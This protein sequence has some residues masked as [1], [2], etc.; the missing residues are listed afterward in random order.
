MQAEYEINHKDED[1]LNRND[2][3]STLANSIINYDDKKTLTIGVMGTWGSGKSSLIN[4]TENYLKKEDVIV[5]RFNPWFFSNQK[6]LYL[7]FFKLII[8]TLKTKEKNKTLFESKIRPKRSLFKKQDNPLQEYFNYIENTSLD[9]KISNF[10]YYDKYWDF[11]EY[12]KQE[13]KKYIDNFGCKIVIIIDDIDRLVD[14]EIAQVFTLVKSLADFDN[15]IYILSFDK[16]IVTKALNNINSE[17]KDDFIDKII[18]IPIN[19]P[20]ISESKM[21]E[22]IQEKIHPIYKELLGTRINNKFNETN[23]VFNYLKLFIKDIRDLKRYLN[24]LIFYKGYFDDELNINDFLLILAIQLFK[25]E[26]FVKIKNNQDILTINRDF[27]KNNPST[28]KSITESQEEF[29]N[30]IKE[31]GEYQNL[32]TFLFPTLNWNNNSTNINVEKM[33]TEHRI[34]ID[35]DFEKYF[36]LSLENKEPSDTLIRKLI[37]MDNV[38]EIYNTLTKRNDRNYNSSLIF[39]FSR[40]ISDIPNQNYKIFIEALM[41]CG[42]KIKLYRSSREYIPQILNQLFEKITPEEEY[43]KLIKT[44]I[45]YPNNVFTISEFVY[46]ISTNSST[47]NQEKLNKIKELAADKIKKYSENKDFLD[48]ELLQDMLYYWEQLDDKVDVKNYVSNNVK[49]PEEILSFLAKFRTKSEPSI[50]SGGKSHLVLDLDK[51]DNYCNLE[52]YEQVIKS[53]NEEDLSDDM[54]ELCET[55]IE[56]YSIYKSLKYING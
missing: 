51:L 35:E 45:D 31:W 5:I 48:M 27:S 6:N 14:S 56:Q 54:I 21:D 47:K 2:F 22:L 46:S 28:S 36:T 53:I 41:K 11:L 40:K 25:Y 43:F 33:Y 17:Y 15:F 42:D 8:S 9:V 49:T 37:Q 55:F 34:C 10:N 20:K 16:L 4:L 23:E 52:Q 50:F 26:L 7:Q 3:A 18:N 30:D 12:H 38:D 1:L 44:Y 24:V 29:K 39:K 19:I 32:L 13:C